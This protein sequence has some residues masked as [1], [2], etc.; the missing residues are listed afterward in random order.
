MPAVVQQASG[1]FGAA[2]TAPTA[3]PTSLPLLSRTAAPTSSR[4]ADGCR[5]PP[6]ALTGGLRTLAAAHRHGQVVLRLAWRPR[7]NSI[8]RPPCDV[9]AQAR[10]VSSGWQRRLAAVAAARHI[11]A[12][13]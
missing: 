7:C 5:L 13:S 1:R 10:S 12:R 8:A 4:V 11:L 6:A 3:L 2:L 9:A